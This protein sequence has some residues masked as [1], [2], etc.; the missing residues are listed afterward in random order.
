MP[1]QKKA[2]IIKLENGIRLNRQTTY[3]HESTYDES[4]ITQNEKKPSKTPKK[5]QKS[6]QVELS[7]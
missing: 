6:N 3:Y 5:N 2:E 1:Y 7:L 4:F